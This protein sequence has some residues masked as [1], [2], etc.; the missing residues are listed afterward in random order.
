MLLRRWRSVCGEIGYPEVI[1]VDQSPE[2]ISRDLDLWAY[3]Y[4]V[5]LDFSRPRKPTD[6]AF[7]GAFNGRFRVECVNVHWF[8]KLA[9]ARRH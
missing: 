1:R 4:G 9:D 3:A 7:I 8:L 6:N 2:F 5:T